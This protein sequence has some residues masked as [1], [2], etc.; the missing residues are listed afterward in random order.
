LPRRV[1]TLVDAPAT[2]WAVAIA[3]LVFAV[4]VAISAVLGPQDADNPLPDVFYVLLWVGLVALSLVVGPVCGARSPPCA[5]CTDCW[6]AG[7]SARGSSADRA[8]CNAAGDGR[9]HLHR[10]VS[11]VRRV[12]GS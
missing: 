11:V 5:P 3:A 9:L 12:G 10:S 1:T 8:A 6:A 2:R 7:R 4:W